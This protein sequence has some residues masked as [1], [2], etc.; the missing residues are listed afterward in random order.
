MSAS[1]QNLT[2]HHPTADDYA[3]VI[4]RLDDWWDGRNMS[5]M[6]PRLFFDHFAGTSVVAED[7][8]GDVVGFLCGFL[9]Q[10]H[11]DVAYIHFVGIDP[12]H[13]RQGL[14]RTLYRWFFDRARRDQR[15]EIH[16]VT[17]PVN[18]RSQAFHQAMGFEATRVDDHDGPGEDRIVFTRHFP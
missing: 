11:P 4:G 10:S 3:Y 15:H 17:S 1:Y 2:L 5:A 8:E 7:E 6:L 13:R 18:E 14:G 12:R 9:S 16:C